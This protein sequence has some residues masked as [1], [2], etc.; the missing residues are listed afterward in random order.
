M[1]ILCQ[2]WIL[3]LIATRYVFG[4]HLKG[5]SLTTENSCQVDQKVLNLVLDWHHRGF[6]CLPTVRTQVKVER[7]EVRQVGLPTDMQVIICRSR[8]RS[9]C[10][11]IY[12][13]AM[14]CLKRFSLN[15]FGLGLVFAAPHVICIWTKLIKCNVSLPPPRFR[16]VVFDQII[17]KEMSFISFPPQRSMASEA[18]AGVQARSKFIICS[19]QKLPSSCNPTYRVKMTII[20]I[21]IQ[22][23]E[24]IKMI[25]MILMHWWR[26]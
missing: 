6:A 2:S 12:A 22:D 3:V 15:V 13:L 4:K 5:N 9:R 8:S 7:L 20:M 11:C 25:Q 1:L 23:E 14:L 16:K 18:E 19:D 21:C 17:K 10:R 24:K 26:W